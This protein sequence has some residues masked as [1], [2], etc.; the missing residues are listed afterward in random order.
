[1]TNEETLTI[2]SELN[3]LIS[4]IM[5]HKSTSDLDVHD[6]SY[7][8]QAVAI[9]F[10]VLTVVGIDYDVTITSNLKNTYCTLKT[11]NRDFIISKCLSCIP[12]TWDGLITELTK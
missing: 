4:N 1:M 2:L 9:Q 3:L 10:N 7:D 11:K 5:Y 6:C 12:E 8:T